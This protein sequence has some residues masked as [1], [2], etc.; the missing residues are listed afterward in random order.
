[1]FGTHKNLNLFEFAQT[2]CC[3]TLSLRFVVNQMVRDSFLNN[4]DN[5]GLVLNLF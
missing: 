1:M 3:Q 5:Y 4:Y 2:A